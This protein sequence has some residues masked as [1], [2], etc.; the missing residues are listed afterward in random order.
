MKKVYV[1]FYK[2]IESTEQIQENFKILHKH[3]IDCKNDFEENFNE[4]KEQLC[5]L[6][7]EEEQSNEGD[8]AD[9]QRQEHVVLVEEKEKG[10]ALLVVLSSRSP[11]TN[12]S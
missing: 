11:Y 1:S 9:I 3:I 8:F 2:F 5:M 10:L 4:L 12:R 7:E 6:I